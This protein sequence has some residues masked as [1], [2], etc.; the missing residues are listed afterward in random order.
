[1]STQWWL[2]SEETIAHIRGA[3]LQAQSIQDERCHETGCR[4]CDL[5]GER[6]SQVYA[7]ALHTLESGLHTPD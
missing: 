6:C 5:S 7:D 2:I 4:L 1:M 3:L